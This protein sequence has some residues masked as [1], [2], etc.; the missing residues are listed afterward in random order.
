[1]FN[2][3]KSKPKT[4]EQ[5]VAHVRKLRAIVLRLNLPR[6]KEFD[7]AT[8]EQLAEIY[9][10]IGSD[11]FKMLLWLTTNIFSV[12]ESAALIHDYCWSRFFND[13]SRERYDYSNNCFRAGNLILA[14]TCGVWFE[15]FRPQQRA[16]FRTSGELLYRVVASP[17]GWGI[18]SGAEH[19]DVEPGPEVMSPWFAVSPYQFEGPGS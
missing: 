9:N 8:D 14:S 6:P 19:V 15:V 4:M 5:K 1:M 16:V 10:G 7:T 11:K 2:F 13:G 17:I 12:F 3:F 18:W